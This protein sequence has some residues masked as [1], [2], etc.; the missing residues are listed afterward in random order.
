[1]NFKH[2]PMLNTAQSVAALQGEI[3]K[4]LDRRIEPLRQAANVQTS[5]MIAE[6]SYRIIG[7]WNLEYT[8]R[9]LTTRSSITIE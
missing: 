7:Q 8:F 3:A 5:S 1:M 6:E 2:K 4:P 9:A